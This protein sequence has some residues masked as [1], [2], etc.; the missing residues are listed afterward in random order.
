MKGNFHVQFGIGGD[1]SDPI[2]DHT[3]ERHAGSTHQRFISKDGATRS[4]LSSDQTHLTALFADEA[5]QQ[6]P[7]KAAAEAFTTP[8]EGSSTETVTYPV[9]PV[10]SIVLSE[11]EREELVQENT[12]RH[13]WIAQEGRQQRE[14]HGHDLRKSWITNPCVISS[15]APLSLET[16]AS[17]CDR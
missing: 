6:E 12:A 17:P 2:A 8:S 4:F 10:L 9:P 3:K 7:Q 16:A 14:V 11:A 5:S 1:G 13:D 15:F